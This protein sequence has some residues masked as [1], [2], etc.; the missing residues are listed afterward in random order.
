MSGTH[1]RGEEMVGDCSLILNSYDSSRY[2]FIR[3]YMIIYIF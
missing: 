1:I 3:V 2:A